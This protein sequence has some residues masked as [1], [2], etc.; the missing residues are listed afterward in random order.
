[1]DAAASAAEANKWI[2]A[3]GDWYIDFS[4]DGDIRPPRE[5]RFEE[6]EQERPFKDKRMRMLR[7]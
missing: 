7:K 5:N 4:D 6:N 2:E 3:D 1:M